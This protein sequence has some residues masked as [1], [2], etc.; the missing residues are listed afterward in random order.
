MLKW[1]TQQLTEARLPGDALVFEMPESIVVSNLKSAREFLQ[2]LDSIKSSFALEQF[3][4]GLNS[5]QLLKQIPVRYVKIDRNYMVGLPG[6]KENELKIREICSQAKHAGKLTI[7]EF[8]EDAASMSILFACGVNF[9]QG[10]FL[11]EPDRTMSYD[12][13]IG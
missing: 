2:G 6:S 10:N 4:L 8:V 11:R 7:A 12:F 9:V 1:I 13:G 3:G 5:F